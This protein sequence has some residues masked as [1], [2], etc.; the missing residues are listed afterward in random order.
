MGKRT[1]WGQYLWIR[2]ATHYPL[3]GVD[4][5][6]DHLMDGLYKYVMLMEIS[7]E[8]VLMDL[9]NKLHIQIRVPNS[10]MPMFQV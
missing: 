3:L 9:I 10:R 8:R 1:I 6:Q 4:R 2:K 5:L 7:L